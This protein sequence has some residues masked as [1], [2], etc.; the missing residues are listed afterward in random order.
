MANTSSFV[1][2]LRPDLQNFIRTHEEDDEKILV[3]KYKEILGVSAAEVAQQIVGRRKSKLKLSHLYNTAGI[4]FPPKLNIEQ[5]SSE[6]TAEFKSTLVS[7][8]TA[9][10]LTGGFGID[11][12]YLSKRFK[13]IVHVEK[14]EKLLEIAKHNHA[15]LGVKNIKHICAD[16]EDYLHST[17]EKFDVAYIDPSRRNSAQKKVFKFADCSP[18][19]IGILPILHQKSK[20]ILIK[21]SP[22][23]DIKQGIRELEDVY[24]VFV[25]G[26]DNECKE[27]LFLISKNK[28]LPTIESVDLSQ[29]RKL[30]FSFTLE[31]E[32]KVKI[33]YAD[34]KAYL[35]EPSAMLLKTGAFKSVANNYNVI[36]LSANTH[37]YTSDKLIDHFPGRVFKVEN[38]LKSDSKAVAALLPDMKA[39]VLTRNYPL[40]PV[41]LKN[42]LKLNDGGN[43]FVI[44]FSGKS[45]KF[46]VLAKRVK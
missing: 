2:L 30:S 15:V 17:E 40:T 14:D 3:L 7:G 29:N 6:L 42:K 25:V 34:P 19:V 9:L 11:S 31:E 16:G 44:G 22:L 4:I 12:L 41:Q 37:L 21:A 1:H 45:K 43:A 32:H 33:S 5:S 13:K 18:D 36:K 24:A 28:M 8:D 39:N 20:S 23:I 10:D 46:L 27:V 38:Y 26:Y 35:Y